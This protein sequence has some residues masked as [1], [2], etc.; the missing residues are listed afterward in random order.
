M[1]SCGG[2]PPGDVHCHLSRGA[3]E[4]QSWQRE[5]AGLCGWQAGRSGAD[6]ETLPVLTVVS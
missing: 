1:P 3:G 5:G 6:K 2:F 4:H